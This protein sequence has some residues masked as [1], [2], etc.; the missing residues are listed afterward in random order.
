MSEAAEAGKSGL[1]TPIGPHVLIVVFLTSF[2]ALPEYRTMLCIVNAGKPI[3]AT[4]WKTALWTI[5]ARW[6]SIAGMC[7]FFV[8]AEIVS[9]V[10]WEFV[11][12]ACFTA[13]GLGWS[14][15]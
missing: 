3:L 12:V 7:T 13:S 4:L 2:K 5:T 1:L 11:P 15:F 9:D 14:N 6:S 10:G 8:I